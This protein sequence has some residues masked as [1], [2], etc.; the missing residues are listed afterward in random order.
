MSPLICNGSKNKCLFCYLLNSLYCS[1][2]F[3]SAV[4]VYITRTT[5]ITTITIC[6]LFLSA[7]NVFASH[8]CTLYCTHCGVQTCK[9]TQDLL[10][11]SHCHLHCLNLLQSNI[12][13]ITLLRPLSYLLTYLSLMFVVG[14]LF[15]NYSMYLLVCILRTQSFVLQLLFILSRNNIVKGNFKCT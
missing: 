2:Y 4:Q 13:S 7:S 10:I 6:S 1:H 14:G 15:E 12:V 11:T 5:V 8:T 9:L 3:C